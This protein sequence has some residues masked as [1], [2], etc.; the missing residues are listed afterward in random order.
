M[1]RASGVATYPNPLFG[2]KSEREGA[3]SA[4]C[5]AS[6]CLGLELGLE[7]HLQIM[8]GKMDGQKEKLI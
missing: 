8:V 4:V 5:F 1:P 6:T 7:A 3:L 2:I